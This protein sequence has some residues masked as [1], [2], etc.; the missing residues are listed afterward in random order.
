VELRENDLLYCELDNGYE[1][2][3]ISLTMKGK[4]MEGTVDSEGGSFPITCEKL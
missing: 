3:E 1:I 2:M 4:T